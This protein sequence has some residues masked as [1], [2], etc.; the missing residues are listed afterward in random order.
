[1]KEYIMSKHAVS[2]QSIRNI[3]MVSKV[4]NF[5]IFISGNWWWTR[6]NWHLFSPGYSIR[7]DNC[8]RY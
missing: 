8:F 1:M 3:I 6:R 7:A 5:R 4:F 2:Q